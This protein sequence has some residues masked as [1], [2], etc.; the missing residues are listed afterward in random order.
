MPEVGG[1][2]IIC[3][4]VWRTR[5]IR[6]LKGCAVV[7]WVSFVRHSASPVKP[8]LSLTESVTGKR[9]GSFPQRSLWSA[10][11]LVSFKLLEEKGSRSKR[12]SNQRTRCWVHHRCGRRLLSMVPARE[13]GDYYHQEAMALD[14]AYAVQWCQLHHQSC[15]P[16]DPRVK[17]EALSTEDDLSKNCGSRNEAQLGLHPE[18][19]Q[20]QTG[21]EGLHCCR[22]GPQAWQIVMMMVIKMKILLCLAAFI[23]HQKKNRSSMKDREGSEQYSRDS[24]WIWII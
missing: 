13:Y 6:Q 4:P 14:W 11:P 20:W 15:N 16:L 3:G 1:S 18:A 22:I 24:L 2:D 21:V 10:R 17:V 19:G 9:M 7:P 8:A 23:Q 5:L 12:T